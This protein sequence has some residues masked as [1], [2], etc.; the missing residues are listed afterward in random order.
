MS[1]NNEMS[2]KV[3][4]EQKS[5]CYSFQC[6]SEVILETDVIKIENDEDDVASIKI[7]AELEN[8]ESGM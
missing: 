4:L 5:D 7:K 2:R 6:S 1:I 3:K 8:V